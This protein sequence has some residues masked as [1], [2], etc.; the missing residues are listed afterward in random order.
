MNAPI[1]VGT[2]WLIEAKGCDAGLLR[3]EEILRGV[4]S[5]VISALGLKTL[6]KNVWHKFEG[7]GAPE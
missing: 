4:F 1:I 5:D 6:G 2:E 7:E 3:D